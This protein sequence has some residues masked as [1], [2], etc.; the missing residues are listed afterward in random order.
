MEKI[1]RLIS[2]S[3]ILVVDDEATNLRLPGIFEKQ[4][5]VNHWDA[6]FQLDLHQR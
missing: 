2:R 4:H 3:R 6:V 5:F 1:D